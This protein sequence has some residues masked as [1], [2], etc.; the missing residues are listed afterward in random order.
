MSV[1]SSAEVLLAPESQSKKKVPNPVELKVKVV[2]TVVFR[3]DRAHKKN[4]E[5]QIK[6]YLYTKNG[7]IGNEL[8]GFFEKFFTR[9]YQ[10]IWDDYKRRYFVENFGYRLH[11]WDRENEWGY[12]YYKVNL[13]VINEK[14]TID[15]GNFI[16]PTFGKLKLETNISFVTMG[17][18]TPFTF[19]EAKSHID[20]AMGYWYQ[21][22]N[23]GNYFSNNKIDISHVYYKVEPFSNTSQS[24]S[25]KRRARTSKRRR[26]QKKTRK[27]RKTN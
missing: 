13:D 4:S 17:W 22:Y 12:E 19:E 11:K 21:T 10:Q 6:S 7:S 2:F 20:A 24:G 5:E 14:L 8:K 26:V 3:V 18:T 1:N 16:R 27:I 15:R 25:G 9:H 23:Y